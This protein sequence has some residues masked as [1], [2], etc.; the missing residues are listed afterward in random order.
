MSKRP[1]T[2][3]PPPF[4][5]FCCKLFVFWIG[6]DRPPPLFLF[7]LGNSSILVMTIIPF[8]DGYRSWLSSH[9]N[10]YKFLISF[11]TN[12]SSWISWSQR[13]SDLR[14]D[15][16]LHIVVFCLLLLDIA[17]LIE[18]PW[19]VFLTNSSRICPSKG[20]ADLRCTVVFCC[21]F[22]CHRLNSCS[23]PL[24]MDHFAILN[25]RAPIKLT[26]KIIKC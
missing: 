26:F 12:A 20:F 10:G 23:F 13:F 4:R 25:C 24:F 5:I 15:D 8:V 16:V 2:P 3:S 18:Y 21:V 9:I 11:L 1:L 7:S 14:C 22:S 19:F 17:W 6:K